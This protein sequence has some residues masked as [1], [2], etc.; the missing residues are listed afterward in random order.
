MSNIAFFEGR[1]ERSKIRPYNEIGAEEAAAADRVLRSRNLSGFLGRGGDAFLGGPEVRAFEHAF[2]TFFGVKHAVSYNSASTALQGA[3]AAIGVGPGDEVITSPYTMSATAMA[4]LFNG[5]VPVFADVDQRTYC[6]DPRS[7]EANV[8]PRTKAILAVNL[9]GTSADYD[10]L[11]RIAKAHGLKIIEDNAQA[12]GGRYHGKYAGTVGDIG[13]FS[14][15]VHKII[16]CGEGG[17]LVTNDDHYAWRAQLYR[18]HG[19]NAI[20]DLKDRVPFEPIACNNFR[21]S[22]VHAAIAHEQL[23]KLNRLIEARRSLAAHLTDRLR[24]ILWLEPYRVPEEIFCVYY[25]YPLRYP[26]KKLG[27]SRKTIAAALA[28]EGYPVGEG[29]QKPLYWLPIFQEKRMYARTQ[30]PFVSSEFPS[31]VSYDMGMCP[32]VERLFSSEMLTTT[33]ILPPNTKECIDGFVN[34]LKR[35]ES[36]AERLIAYEKE[37]ECS[38]RGS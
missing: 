17:V 34:A 4:V 36:S 7:V 38:F 32:T 26:E 14:L 9:F 21:L 24:E 6:L 33:A 5:A 12:A 19:E 8:S 23:K 15:N 13:V 18:N 16:Q 30:F 10:A 2:K 35:I 20:D 31:G 1:E 25:Q 3:L 29:Y 37:N 11:M 28:A 22:E 27:V